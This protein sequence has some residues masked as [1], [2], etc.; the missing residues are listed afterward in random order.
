MACDFGSTIPATVP[1]TAAK[2]GEKNIAFLENLLA[3]GETSREQKLLAAAFE[4]GVTRRPDGKGGFGLGRM[5]SLVHEFENGQLN[6]FSGSASAIIAKTE[7]LI[8]RALPRRFEG[9][10]VLWSLKKEAA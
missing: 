7:K 8:T 10:Y 6:V 1:K 2:G 3:V 4:E 5:A 9:T